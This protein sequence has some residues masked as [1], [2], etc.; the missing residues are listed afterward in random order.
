MIISSG[1]LFSI[2]NL[3]GL[4]LCNELKLE[5]LKDKRKDARKQRFILWSLWIPKEDITPSIKRKQKERKGKIFRNKPYKSYSR[6][7]KLEPSIS[8]PYEKKP[9]HKPTKKSIACF[10]CGKIGY[11]AKNCRIKQKIKS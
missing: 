4:A 2:V 3:E 1:E 8:K 6:Y 10:K 5:N 9:R 11:Y 7:K